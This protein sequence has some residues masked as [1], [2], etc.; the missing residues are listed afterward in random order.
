M[1][2]LYF[3]PNFPQDEEF[4]T[5][6]PQRLWKYKSN[7]DYYLGR[8]PTFPQ[9]LLLI[10]YKYNVFKLVLRVKALPIKGINLEYNKENLG[11]E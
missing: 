8:F 2:E 9:A 4:S 3:C 11:V 1:V 5:R 7:N 6:F 10:L